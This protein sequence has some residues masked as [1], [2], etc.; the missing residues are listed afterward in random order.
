[1]I[2]PSPSPAWML[3]TDSPDQGPGAPSAPNDAALLDDYS[4][5]VSDVVDRVGPS[6]VRID[7]RKNGRSAGSGSGV[8]IS[9]DGLALT[10]S[11]VV[12]G[13]R[14]VSLTTLEGRE[15]Q[16]RVLGDDPDTDLALLRVEAD[17]SL[18]AAK[19]GD[20][21]KLKRGQIAIAIG[22]P[23]GFDAT[24]T[25]GVVSALGRSLQ[26]RTGR[27]IEDVV[28]TDAPLNPG[29]SGGPLV[30][31]TGEVIGINTAVIMGAQGICFAVASNT[32]S[33]VAGEIARHGRVRR[34]YIGVGA[35]TLAIPRRIA[36]RLGSPTGH[37]RAAS[38]RRPGGTGRAGRAADRRPGHRARRQAG[39]ERQRPRARA[40]R[41]QDRPH[42]QRRF[43]APVG[44]AEAVDRTGGAPAGGVS[45][46]LVAFGL[47]E[48][49]RKRSLRL[50]LERLLV[51]ADEARGDDRADHG[52]DEHGEPD[53]PR[54]ML[55]RAAEQIAASAEDRR[56]DDPAR[57]VE[58]KERLPIVAID[59]GEKRRKSPQHR[60]EA[61]EKHDLAAVLE[62]EIL[63]DLEPPLVQANVVSVS[64]D[65]RKAELAADPIAAIVA[66]DRA[67]RRRSRS[68]HRC[69]AFHGRRRSRR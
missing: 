45:A 13:S 18:P 63:P 16:A 17:V 30:S 62:E 56:P 41:R 33:F 69:S 29:N 12:Q 5:V 51:G 44:A 6:V 15:L 55:E 20:S 52:D 38:Q 23:L 64:V 34:A 42:R 4:R 37:G 50:F 25:A 65:E 31:S 22:N 26:S 61:A 39:D 35:A 57:R 46:V 40:R 58:E 28:Q 49:S 53:G 27:M 2:E 3:D 47:T 7:V 1:M 36:L 60:D 54:V 10:N 21:A 48:R 9:S 19:L 11:H 14:T 67:R 68:P 66:E 24:V 32:A 8:I 43:S 59:A